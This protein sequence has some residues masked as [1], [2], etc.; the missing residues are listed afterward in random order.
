MGGRSWSKGVGAEV[1]RDGYLLFKPSIPKL[2]AN[3]NTWL[4]KYMALH[5]T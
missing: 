1:P 4:L 3:G 2:V 5:L